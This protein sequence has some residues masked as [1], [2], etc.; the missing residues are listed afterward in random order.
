MIL[1]FVIDAMMSKTVF[2][3]FAFFEWI[4]VCFSIP[5][6]QKWIK[7]KKNNN[8]VSLNDLIHLHS[9]LIFDHFDVNA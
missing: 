9:D 6:R 7:A 1:I 3:L 8:K 5:Q 2:E 4:Y